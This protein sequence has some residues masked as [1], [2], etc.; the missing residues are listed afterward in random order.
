[1]PVRKIKKEELLECEKIQSVAFAY[2]LDTAALEKKLAEEPEPIDPYIGFFNDEN[3]LTACME[4]PAYQMRYEGSWVRMVGLGGVASL[5]EYRFGGAIR[6]IIQTAFHQM[7]ESD[8][9]FSVL[10]PFSHAYYRKFG[11][12]LCQLMTEYE[13]PLSALSK[14]RYTGKARMLQPGDSL[15]GLKSVFTAHFQR[16]NMSVQREDRHWK[17]RLG[18][19]AYKERV[20]TYLLEDENGP[21]AYL[22]MAV[23]TANSSEKLGRVRELAYVHPQGF[24]DVL[25]FLYRLSAQYGKL[26]IALPDDIPLAALLDESYDIKGECCEQQMA[27]VIQVKRA[28]E[29]K[30][31]FEGAAYTLRVRDEY[32]PEND[33]IFSVRCEGGT[34]LVEK[35]LQT[36]TVDHMVDHMVDLT[37]D[38]RTLTQ[39]L[40]GFLSMDEALYKPDVTVTANLETLRRVFVKRPVFLTDHF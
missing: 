28:L 19:D 10:Y 35:Q 31:H 30:T 29:G 40:L 2:S 16:Y 27:R 18:E 17:K 26:R 23:E 22:V 33:G 24:S 20:Y 8:A 25:G 32:L 7:V 6:Q 3:V 36:D 39:L 21:S 1:M 4:L 5:P 12:E 15:D 9:V 37:V 38:V 14:F 11:Y 34:V 13:V